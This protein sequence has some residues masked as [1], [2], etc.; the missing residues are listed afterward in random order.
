MEED[1]LE[2]EL[3]HFGAAWLWTDH[4]PVVLFPICEMNKI[5][6]PILPGA[7]EDWMGKHKCMYCDCCY[8]FPK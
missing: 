8:M 1:P 7:Y 3:S 6:L 5:I 4:F 2:L